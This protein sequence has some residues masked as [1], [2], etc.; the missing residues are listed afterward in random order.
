MHSHRRLTAAGALLAFTGLTLAGC[1]IPASIDRAPD[2]VPKPAATQAIGTPGEDDL[3][4]RYGDTELRVEDLG[5]AAYYDP[6]PVGAPVIDSDDVYVFVRP[7]GWTFFAEQR[8]VDN[9]CGALTYE[10]ETTELGDGWYKVTPVGE[11]AEYDLYL[12][13]G[14]GPGLPL[15]GTVGAARA[16]A[17][18]QTTKSTDV[19]ASAWIDVAAFPDEEGYVR[20]G[21]ADLPEHPE[22]MTASATL[23][24]GGKTVKVDLMPPDWAC[25]RVG[26]LTLDAVLTDD[27]AKILEGEDHTFTVELVLDGVAH[28]ATGSTGSPYYNELSFT[29]A[30]P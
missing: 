28:T 14:S 2:A 7:A 9:G 22:T 4:V 26:D 8:G 30:L 19:E 6:A 27:E 25:D 13:A 21:V 24:S 15:G 1:A 11:A 10:P 12:T 5:E 29:P 17:K 3:I 20:V 18:W 16:V 23:T